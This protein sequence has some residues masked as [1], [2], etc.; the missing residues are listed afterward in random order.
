MKRMNRKFCLM[1][2]LAMTMM[3]LKEK[4]EEEY[5]A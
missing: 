3:G 4:E 5:R 1:A 2:F